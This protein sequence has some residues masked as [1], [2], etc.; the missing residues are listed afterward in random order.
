[1]SP[2]SATGDSV[3]SAAAAPL[4]TTWP[5][6]VASTS[7]AQRLRDSPNQSSSR[8]WADPTCTAMRTLSAEPSLHIRRRQPSLRID[9]RGDGGRHRREGHAQTVTRVLELDA[10]MPTDRGA[11]KFVVLPEV[12]QHPGI[13]GPAPSG[14]LQVGEQ[15]HHRLDTANSTTRPRPRTA[16]LSPIAGTVALICAGTSARSG[17][18]SRQLGERAG[19]T[20][21]AG[22]SVQRSTRD[23]TLRRCARD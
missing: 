22:V 12:V 4:S 17:R 14:T 10:G 15:Q 6:W 18:A 21:P 23:R 5:P 8:R 3:N 7:R 20:V 2:T 19:P 11:K 16:V 9:R 1:M 13:G